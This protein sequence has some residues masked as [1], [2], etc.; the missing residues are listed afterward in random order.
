MNR[1]GFVSLV[2]LLVS[3]A[4][5]VSARGAADTG[6]PMVSIA[7]PLAGATLTES[8]TVSATASDDTRVVGVQFL[9]DGQPLGGEV[10]SPPYRVPWRIT[11]SGQSGFHVLS[12][13]ARDAAGH[14]MTAAPVE[15]DVQAVDVTHDGPRFQP[16]PLPALAGRLGIGLVDAFTPG[17]SMVAGTDPTATRL[18]YVPFNRDPALRRDRVWYRTHHREWVM[19]RCDRTRPATLGSGGHA[20]LD[21]ANPRVRD[22]QLNVLVRHGVK[23]G[24]AGIYVDGLTLGHP[25][26]GPCGHYTKDGRWVPQYA[27]AA[28]DARWAADVEAWLGWMS[29]KIHG[30]GGFVVAGLAYV[31]G[32]EPGAK[33]FRD[34]QER[35][36]A[37][38][39]AVLLEGGGFVGDCAPR[40][41]PAWHE[42]FETYRRLVVSGHAVM[43]Q[44]LTCDRLSDLTA[45]LRSWVFANHLLVR[46]DKTYLMIAPRRGPTTYDGAEYY[47]PIGAPAGEP[48]E[49]DGVYARPN[50]HGLVAVNPDA[51][52][53]RPLHL[54]STAYVDIKGAHVSGGQ[55]VAGGQLFNGRTLSGTVVMPPASGL[56]LLR[57]GVDTLAAD[58]PAGRAPLAVTFRGYLVNGTPGCGQTDWYSML[59]GDGTWEFVTVP[60]GTC[61][62]HRYA[63]AHTYARPGAYAAVLSRPSRALPSRTVSIPLGHASITVTGP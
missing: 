34:R 41:G 38:L 4:S 17:V 42:R 60:A 44:E 59:F 5:I 63:I 29:E 14:R 53:P 36:T 37:K 25:P 20:V 13:V 6:P 58:V 49:R 46:G 22:Y 7:S 16:R 52:K 50:R 30:L 21:I 32:S 35:I 43:T 57:P 39:D 40:A 10:T 55:L 54:G 1:R 45:E 61:G 28:A 51:E 9:L 33:V 56:V 2:A 27:D 23:Q 12:A 48:V 3:L 62:P 47:L 15:V 26:G 31:E 8:T 24:R 18:H 19:Y 11:S